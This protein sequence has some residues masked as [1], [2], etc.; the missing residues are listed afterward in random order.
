M[1]DVKY[2]LNT[3]PSISP[4]EIIIESLVLIAFV[5]VAG[6]LMLALSVV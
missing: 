5:G 3:E 1:N 2:L 6:A 4:L